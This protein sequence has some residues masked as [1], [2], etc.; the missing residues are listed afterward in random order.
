MLC[1]VDRAA[2]YDKMRR[3]LPLRTLEIPIHC[4]ALI[5]EQC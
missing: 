3:L 5:I 1:I 4:N 2:L